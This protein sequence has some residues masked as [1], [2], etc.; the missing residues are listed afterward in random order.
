MSQDYE[1][2][3]AKHVALRAEKK[4]NAEAAAL[5]QAVEETKANERR[6]KI[7]AANAVA[8]EKGTLMR[9]LAK[10]P[11]MRNHGQA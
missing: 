10:Y 5:R 9:L 8:I 7:E 3:K 11:E 4:A 6:K 2:T 1:A